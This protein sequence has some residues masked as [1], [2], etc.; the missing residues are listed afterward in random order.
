MTRDTKEL[1]LTGS[2]GFSLC[3]EKQAQPRPESSHK[4]DFLSA[5][6]SITSTHCLFSSRKSMWN[7]IQTIRDDWSATN[8]FAGKLAVALFY[9]IVWFLILANLYQAL[10]DP[11]SFGQGCTFGNAGSTAWLILLVRLWAYGVAMSFIYV[12]SIGAKLG[13]IAFVTFVVWLGIG[14][15]ITFT[16]SSVKQISKEDSACLQDMEK[17]GWPMQGLFL[18]T[19]FLMLLDGKNRGA[20]SDYRALS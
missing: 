15:I 3:Q 14:L 16:G 1:V 11:S 4:T 12:C 9:S 18:L 8:S 19:F 17:F 10:V 7:P 20:A 6:T 13:N 2:R 5:V